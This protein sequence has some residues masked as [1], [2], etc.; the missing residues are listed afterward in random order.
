MNRVNSTN[1]LQTVLP[2]DSAIHKRSCRQ[3]RNK[4]NDVVDKMIF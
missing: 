3:Y 2:I 1:C 4:Y